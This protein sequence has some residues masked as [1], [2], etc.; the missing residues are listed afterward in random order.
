MALKTKQATGLFDRLLIVHS[1]EISI[2]S[3]RVRRQMLK[4]LRS[5]ISRAIQLYNEV[6]LSSNLPPVADLVI[7]SHHGRLYVNY[8]FPRLLGTWITLLIT[9]IA[10]VAPSKIVPTDVIILKDTVVALARTLISPSQSF[11]LRVRREGKHEFTSQELA[12]EL[13][14]AIQEEIYPKPQVNLTNPDIE[15]FL[16]VRGEKTFV[17]VEKING[18]GGL[19]QGSQGTLMAE[20]LPHPHE[21]AAALAMMRRGVAIYPIIFDTGLKVDFMEF[22]PPEI[23]T[24]SEKHTPASGEPLY[25]LQ[26]TPLTR[27]LLSNFACGVERYVVVRFQPPLEKIFSQFPS[28]EACSWCLSVRK[29]VFQ[30]ISHQP[31]E[32]KS[33]EAREPALNIGN[34]ELGIVMGLSFKEGLKITP[35]EL[36]LI[37]KLFN[38]NQFTLFLP[39]LAVSIS[40][41]EINDFPSLNAVSCCPYQQH[42][43]LA[44]TTLEQLLTSR[45]QDLL[46]SLSR[47]V[48]IEQWIMDESH[49]GWTKPLVFPNRHETH[50]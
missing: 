3:N 14:S 13:G 20:V 24:S 27:V 40:E 29:N 50:D 17:Y 46:T 25:E 11:A 42:F 47:Q 33:T 44:K 41:L 5:N 4:R 35:S 49:E 12:V 48:I 39:C 45:D 9:G 15:I 31:N 26:M 37:Q 32:E 22:K 10:H 23:I 38:K 30:E 19:P 28:S 34:S 43:Q 8:Q 16:D 1:G 18:A 36:I 21:I 7:H 6:A 2:K